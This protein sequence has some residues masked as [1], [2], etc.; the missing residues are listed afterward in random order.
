M[1]EC[2]VELEMLKQLCGGLLETV[3]LA[4]ETCL[5][6]LVVQNRALCNKVHCCLFDAS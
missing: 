3:W 2:V 5:G 1:R 4:R 6:F